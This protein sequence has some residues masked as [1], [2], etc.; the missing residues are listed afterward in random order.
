[1]RHDS[2]NFSSSYSSL[3]VPTHDDD[4]D[5]DYYTTC[6]SPLLS[7]MTIIQNKKSIDFLLRHNEHVPTKFTPLT[8]TQKQNAIAP[9]EEQKTTALTE[10]NYAKQNRVGGCQSFPVLFQG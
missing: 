4:D 2:Y 1:M 9:I 3:L 5:N 8:I 10:P 7:S 6:I